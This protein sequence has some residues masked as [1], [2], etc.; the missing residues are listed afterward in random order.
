M[1]LGNDAAHLS[2][3]IIFLHEIHIAFFCNFGVG[4][5]PKVTRT[6]VE[7]AKKALHLRLRGRIGKRRFR[8]KIFTTL[9][10]FHKNHVFLAQP[11]K[12]D[13]YRQLTTMFLNFELI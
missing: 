11:G 5:L 13:N 3:D 12:R 7:D 1:S 2:Y 9:F 4:K 10:I 8:F 6:E